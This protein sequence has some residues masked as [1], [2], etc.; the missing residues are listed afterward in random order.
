[1]HIEIADSK[2]GAPS[3]RSFGSRASR[4]PSPMKLK[5]N[6]VTA[7]NRPGRSASRARFH[8]VGAVGDQHAPAEVSGSW[9]PRPRKDRKLS[10]RITPAP[11]A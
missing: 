5:Q 7:M 8:L 11:S 6:S 2:I 1:M 10:A 9:M 3:Q 4:R